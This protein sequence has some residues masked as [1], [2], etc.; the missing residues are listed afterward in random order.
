MSSKVIAICHYIQFERQQRTL[1]RKEPKLVPFVHSVIIVTL[2]VGNGSLHTEN[3]DIVIHDLKWR[4][5]HPVNNIGATVIPTHYKTCEQYFQITV[6]TDIEIL[7]H[8]CQMGVIWVG[9]SHHHLKYG[10]LLY[11]KQRT[12]K[13]Y[14]QPAVLQA[15]EKRARNPV[16]KCPSKLLEPAIGQSAGWSSLQGHFGTELHTRFFC[17][18]EYRWPRFYHATEFFY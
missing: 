10:K 11:S 9:Q 18:M 12:S 5:V 8:N 16:P 13:V 17:R 1:P 3:Q 4:I 15:E 14:T 2:V 6:S 7:V